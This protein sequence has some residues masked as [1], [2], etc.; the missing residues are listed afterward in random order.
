MMRFT[1]KHGIVHEVTITDTQPQA[2]RASAARSCPGQ[3]LFQY[4]NGDGEPQPITSSDV[5]DYIREAT[6]GDFT[7]KHFRTWGAS[8]IA[9]DQLLKKA[10]ARAD[11]RQDR[12]RAGRRSA[13]QHRRDEPQVL[14]PSRAARSG[15]GAIRATRWTAWSGRARANGCR[16]PKS[17]LLEFLARGGKRTAAQAER[18]RS[19]AGC[20]RRKPPL[21]CGC[22]ASQDRLMAFDRIDR[23][24]RAEPRRAADR[25]RRRRWR[26]SRSCCW[27]RSYGRA[28]RRARSRSA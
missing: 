3:M 19:A 8:V 2:H 7:A 13:R 24:V 6:G 9:F 23:L 4:V 21:D 25:A 22:C 12:D 11:Q 1:G 20:R 28:H 27:L 26:S 5:N 17:A 14:C 15:Q 10:E 16:A 18:Q